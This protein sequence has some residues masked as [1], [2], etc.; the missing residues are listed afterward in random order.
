MSTPYAPFSHPKDNQAPAWAS[1][2]PLAPAPALWMSVCRPGDN[3][4]RFREQAKP[5]RV[6][7]P[8]R[9]NV[10]IHVYQCGVDGC[11]GGCPPG[12]H[13]GEEWRQGERVAPVSD[14]R[15]R[16]LHRRYL[17]TGAVADEAAL[18]S[19][20][21]RSGE[22]TRERLELAAYCGHEASRGAA[23]WL[24][25]CGHLWAAH[26]AARPPYKHLGCLYGWG[27]G[28]GCDCPLPP[29]ASFQFTGDPLQTRNTTLAEWVSGLS[30]W[31]SAVAVRA[32]VALGRAVLVMAGP[33]DGCEGMHAPLDPLRALDCAD[34][35]ERIQCAEHWLED[36]CSAR[37][38]GCLGGGSALSVAHLG[39]LLWDAAE[40][41]GHWLPDPRAIISASLVSHALGAP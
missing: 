32:A 21:L 37:L 17:Q 16:D 6:G 4:E 22:L 18:L 28:S 15:L 26:D 9:I 7:P 40:Y 25:S 34:L 31:G 10:G 35:D 11:Y 8:K 20:R 24:C 33:H 12:H 27:A 1:R 38:D 3:L 29:P 14:G 36:P 30:R 41:A 13:G 5:W 2:E 23:G 19:E 39:E